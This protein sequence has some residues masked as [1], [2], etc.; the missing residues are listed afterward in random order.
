MS[1][2]GKRLVTLPE[3]TTCVVKDGLVTISGPLGKSERQFDSRLTVT[4]EGNV[5]QVKPLKLNL[6]TNALWGTY[7]SHLINM[8][9][10]V[11]TGFQ[12][13]LTI[14]GVGYRA[15]LAGDK[16][17]FALGFSHPIE[18]KIPEGIKVVVDK[19]NLTISGTDKELVGHFAAKI[20]DYR[21]PEPYKGKGIRYSTETVRRKAGKKVTA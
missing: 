21:P 6:E 1:R 7:A 18:L 15:T 3:K 13:Q 8:V 10:G 17:V 19:S 12:K 11:T 9:T 5:A 4:V 2:I 20:R 14:E 16:L